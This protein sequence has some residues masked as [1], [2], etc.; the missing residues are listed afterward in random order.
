[1]KFKEFCK[2]HDEIRMKYD[3]L[4]LAE[5]I[6]LYDEYKKDKYT[7][8]IIFNEIHDCPNYSEKEEEYIILKAEELINKQNKK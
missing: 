1:M 5:L 7:S 8:R 6:N 4:V 2:R 3:I